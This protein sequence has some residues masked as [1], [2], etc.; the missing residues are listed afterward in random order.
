MIN[1]V[2]ETFF[3]FG[4]WKKIEA[5]LPECM[6]NMATL[7]KWLISKLFDIMGQLDNIL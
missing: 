4:I 1:S 2:T 7:Q 6:I 3:S 5:T